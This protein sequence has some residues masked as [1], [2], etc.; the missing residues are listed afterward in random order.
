ME[1]QILK[2][3]PVRCLKKLYDEYAKQN[4]FDP[5]QPTINKSPTDVDSKFIWHE[6]KEIFMF[7][8]FQSKS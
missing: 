3:T 8:Y 4:S 1:S 5:V 6:K 7:I 2:W